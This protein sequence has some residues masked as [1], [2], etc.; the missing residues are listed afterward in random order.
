MKK[1]I[2][3]ALMIFSFV[4]VFAES[5]AATKSAKAQT[6]TIN[7]IDGKIIDKNTGEGLAGVVVEVE[8]ANKIY[9]TDF[10]GNFAIH[11]LKPGVYNLVV[12][13]VSY[14]NVKLKEVNT[15]DSGAMLKVEL[16]GIG[17]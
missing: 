5:K 9:Y 14:Q 4:T 17:I 12:K 1:L 10:D 8:G 6:T 15:T 2:F 16:E 11:D 7:H 13:Y 3:T